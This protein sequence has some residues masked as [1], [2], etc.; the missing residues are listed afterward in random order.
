MNL[1]KLSI[2]FLNNYQYFCFKSYE[3]LIFKKKPW[4]NFQNC[5]RIF[6]R[7]IVIFLSFIKILGIIIKI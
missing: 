2:T 4:I 7:V 1:P 5:Y 3:A 6:Y